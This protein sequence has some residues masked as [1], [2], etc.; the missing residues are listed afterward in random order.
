MHFKKL[1]LS[2]IVL[3]LMLTF[4]A[5]ADHPIDHSPLSKEA[6]R[7]MDLLAQ[8]AEL[9]AA[10]AFTATIEKVEGDYFSPTTWQVS[11][12]GGTAP[13]QFYYELL[14]LD[15]SLGD[16]Y[17]IVTYRNYTSENTLKETLVAS[18]TYEIRVWIDDAD[19][20][21]TYTDLRFDAQDDAFP[22]LE[23][24]VSE[25]A[26]E[27]IAAGCV[28][29][30]DK[31]LWLHDWLVM[32]AKYDLSYTYYGVDGVLLRQTGVCDSYAK[33]YLLLLKA[34]NVQGMY[35]SGLANGGN[36]AWNAIHL[37]GHW[38][39]VDVTWDDPTGVDEIISGHERHIYF[40]LP[41][42]IMSVNHTR[43]DTDSP[44][45]VCDSYDYNYYIHNGETDL[46]TNDFIAAINASLAEGR[47]DADVAVP[48]YYVVRVDEQGTWT[49]NNINDM[50]PYRLAAE[51]LR[52]MEWNADGRTV[53]MTIDYSPDNIHAEIDFTGRELR[54]PAELIDVES[55]AFEND[56]GFMSVTLSDAS[57]TV[58][59][60]AFANA[61]ALWRVIVPNANTVIDDSAFD[62]SYHLTLVGPAG[63]A[64]EAYANAHG[65]HFIA[66]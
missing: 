49:S 21:F 14:R 12:E 18:G 5:Q 8:N 1:F 25:L 61:D 29:D 7:K 64:A 20:H 65:F 38:Y 45:I 55:G 23:E 48:D 32:H 6:Y 26:N 24:R 58:G 40:A 41:D 11:V 19:N 27:C 57:Q 28:S 35:V 60:N 34:A 33:A 9:Q 62:D 31:A 2:L 66:D 13:Y 3:L 10:S 44:A 54:L 30:F 16:G 15:E 51:A 17:E 59:P 43:T 36:H 42:E 4:A 39:W 52:R 53:G 37:D 50:L 63:G 56:T 47:Y 46:W 22:S